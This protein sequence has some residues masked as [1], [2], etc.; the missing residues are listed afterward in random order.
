LTVND[1]AV[2]DKVPR[3]YVMDLTQVANVT[4]NCYDPNGV[5][6]KAVRASDGSSVYIDKRGGKH[7]IPDGGT[8]ECVAAQSG[9]WPYRVP[10]ARLTQKRYE[11]AKCVRAAPG[12]I[13]RH[14]DGDA[15]IING[16]WTRGWIPDAPSY[17]CYRAE[18]RKVVTGVPRYFV[19]DLTAA[20][21]AGYP[22]GHCLVRRPNGSAY[23]VN[24]EGQ[25]EWVP[26]TPTWDCEVGR[27]VP[28]LNSTDAL[29]DS[30]A[31]VGWH[32]CLNKANL[33]GKILR[34]VDGDAHYIHGDDTRTWIPDEFTYSCRTR[35]G[36]PV[37]DTRWREYVNAF[38]DTGWDYCFDLNTFK[39]R[40]IRHPDGDIYFVDDRGVRHWVPNAT[41]QSCLT[42]R[43][44]N[45]AT[46]RWRE[47]IDRIPGGDWAVCGDTLR[48]NQNFDMGQWLQSSN[49]A[50][51]LVMQSDANLVLYHGSR[52]I[53]ASG[54][55]GK[56]V[57]HLKLH[58]NGCLALIDA[59]G[60]WLW[61]PSPDPCNK[62][63]D[64]LVVQSDGN[65]VL[66]A[67][68]R[69]VWAS[70]TAGR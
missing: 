17:A 5:K 52:A 59:R 27:N 8:Y 34:H 36:T 3:Y 24:D 67:G 11:D 15:Y 61:R 43:Y 58:D 68:S 47:Y 65:L 25:K 14:D 55:N 12:D 66:Y 32:Y 10:V 1:H 63:G 18:G 48:R 40:Y 69:A 49:G 33:R 50:Y 20:A 19:D 54:T 70:N 53:W 46:V 41:V 2:V 22:S 29:V 13:I 60:N 39:N 51:R 30:I 42:S 7:W 45:P 37:V 28:V 64:R 31:E 16:N 38:R 57:H 62:G 6:G 21:T 23:F 44:G 9:A 35:A 4:F 56:A 26:D